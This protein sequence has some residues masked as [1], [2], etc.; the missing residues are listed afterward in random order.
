MTPTI[1]TARLVLRPLT[2]ASPRNIA[3]LRDPEV[4]R[5]SEQRHREHTL[6]SQLRYISSFGGK[7]CLWGIYLVETGEHI[8]NLSA[9]HDE[10]NNVSDVGILIG[11]S[12]L[13]GQG[14]ASEAWKAACNQMLDKDLGGIRKLECGCMKSNEA[15]MKLAR[16]SGFTLEGERANH[17]LLGGGM[18]SLVQFGRMR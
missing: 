10:P 18:V 15:M 2:K 4:V 17:F 13:W 14:Y 7:S 9:M 16:K 1:S 6:S 8:G 11:E 12:R 3:W 5:Y